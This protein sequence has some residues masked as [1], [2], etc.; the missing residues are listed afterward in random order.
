MKTIH[1]HQENWAP[2]FTGKK[3]KTG[4]WYSHLL[5][6]AESNRILSTAV[7]I[8]LN[9]TIAAFSIPFLGYN[10]VS[11]FTYCIFMAPVFLTNALVLAQVPMKWIIPLFSISI[12]VNT[13]A[14]IYGLIMLF[15]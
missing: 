6:S 8:L 13:S 12:F 9:V 11:V 14:F 1:L 15:N 4:S 2:S 5:E 10:F 7:L 3:Q